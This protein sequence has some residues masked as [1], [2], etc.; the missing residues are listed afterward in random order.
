M[1]TSR[2]HSDGAT[3]KPLLVCGVAPLDRGLDELLQ[4]HRVRGPYL[5]I[6][7]IVYLAMLTA[8]HP[9]P[10]LAFI[11]LYSSPEVALAAL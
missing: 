6:C 11:I 10:W 2:S 9:F 3:L 1:Y 8:R 7:S 4:F 5:A